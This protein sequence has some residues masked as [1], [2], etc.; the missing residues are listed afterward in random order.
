[1]TNDFIMNLCVNDTRRIRRDSAANFR[2]MHAP[3][4]T[5]ANGLG[6]SPPSRS[7]ETHE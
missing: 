7:Q 2:Y 4:L 6:L 5:F 1:M 3:A